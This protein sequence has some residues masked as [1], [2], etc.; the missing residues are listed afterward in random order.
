MSLRL[1]PWVKPTIKVISTGLGAAI[2]G[3]LGGAVGQWLG[4]ALSA[5]TTKLLEDWTKKLGEKATE[6]LVDV[7]G[8]ALAD[9]LKPAAAQLAG[10]Y[11][12]T[13]RMSLKEIRS[14]PELVPYS[15]WFSHWDNALKSNKLLELSSGVAQD[16]TSEGITKAFRDML[17]ALDVLGGESPANSRALPPSL[18]D[19]VDAI[20]PNVALRHFRQLIATPEYEAA[21][22][23]AQQLLWE[24]T[25]SKLDAIAAD[26]GEVLRAIRSTAFQT[27]KNEPLLKLRLDDR[28]PRALNIP[29]ARNRDNDVREK[30]LQ[31]AKR[32]GVAFDREEMRHL[33][34]EERDVYADKVKTWMAISHLALTRQHEFQTDKHRAVLLLFNIVNIGRAPA[35]KVKITLTFPGTVLIRHHESPPTTPIPVAPERPLSLGRAL[36][37]P[38]G[39]DID[40]NEWYPDSTAPSLSLEEHISGFELFRQD[41]SRTDVQVYRG[42][43]NH[44]EHQAEKANKPLWISFGYDSPTDVT[45]GYQLHASNQPEDVE[46]QITISVGEC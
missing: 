20:L 36:P 32:Q 23:Q 30:L 24:T 14:R 27:A 26:V 22:R 44:L 21:W 35:D 13:L 46:G 45:I 6:T 43:I 4:E 38:T 34:G 16:L 42:T 15:D 28:T 9:K 3:P 1:Q 12:E 29:R 33:E 11:E 40:S 25:Q 39:G 19:A 17:R 31:K 5:P 37:G 2:A 18:G 8:E 41:R 10:L 7:G